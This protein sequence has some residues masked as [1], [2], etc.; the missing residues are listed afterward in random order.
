MIVV[1]HSDAA[2]EVAAITLSVARAN[3]WLVEWQNSKFDK[4]LQSETWLR[5]LIIHADGRQET[6]AGNTGLSRFSKSGFVSVD[7]FTPLNTGMK[8]SL[9]AAQKIIDAHEGKRTASGVW[10]RN[11]RITDQGQGRGGDSA[12]W[13]TVIVADFTYDNFN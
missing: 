3:S 9:D 10:F 8:Q 6:L 1:N 12:W 11:V 5:W 2:S 13:Q 7:C 4:P